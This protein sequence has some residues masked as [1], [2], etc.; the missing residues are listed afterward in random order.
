MSGD[1]VRVTVQV[2]VPPEVAFAVFTEEIDQWWG[3]GPAFRIAGRAPGVLSIEP[4]LGGRIFEQGADGAPLWD[5][6]VVTAWEPPARL[7]FTWRSVRFVPG[8][9]TDVEVSFASYGSGTRVTV[10]HRGWTTIRPDHPVRH[11]EPP[12]VFLARMGG[13]WG[14]LMTSLRAHAGARDS[15]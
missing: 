1:R 10:E 7:R 9:S 3:R 6:G 4:R 14:S 11:G 5:V 15:L 2:R 13:W 12:T 8:E